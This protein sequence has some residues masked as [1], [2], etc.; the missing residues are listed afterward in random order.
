MPVFMYLEEYPE[1]NGHQ[2]IAEF[3]Q[4][5]EQNQQKPAD[6]NFEK[7]CKVAGLRPEELQSLLG[8]KEH[9]TRNQLANR[10]S[11]VITSEI[12]RLWKDRP[13]KVRF[14]TDAEHINTFVSDPNATFDVEVNLNERSRAFSGSFRSM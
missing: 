5:K 14:D 11:A 13:L 1:L 9:E 12:R 2:N 8:Q 4:R 10:A 7:M 3:L 6:V